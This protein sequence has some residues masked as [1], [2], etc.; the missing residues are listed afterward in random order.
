M[1]KLTI[2]C[3]DDERNVLL[4]LRT[5]L[6]RY[7]PEHSIEIA[8]SGVE[9]LELIAELL[10][11]GS[12]VPLVISDQIMPGMK[13]DQLLIELHQRY[14]QIV[15]V[16]LTGQARA[17]DVG[18]VVN[19]GNLYR[20][21]SKP[22]NEVDLQL[23]VSEALRRYQQ[24][25]QLAQQQLALEHSNQA[26]E[27]LNADLAQ[28]VQDR[29][30]SLQQALQNRQRTEA[31]L[32]VSEKQYRLLSEIS[33]MGIFRADL[34]GRCTY[35][36]ARALEIAGLSLA[37]NLA[38]GWGKTVHPEDRDDI[39]AAWSEFVEQVNLGHEAEYQIEHRY[40][41]PDHSIRWILVQ[42]VPERNAAGA[43]GCIGSMIDITEHK[44]LEERLQVTLE[45]L[46][47]FQ[48]ELHVQNEE[49][50]LLSRTAELEKI[51]YQDL[52][53]FAPDGYLVTD[54]QG[55]IQEANQAASDLLASS[56][57]FLVGKPLILFLPEPDRR[58]L[59][60]RLC[61]L[62]SLQTSQQWE[63]R[64]KPRNR[65]SFPA[66]ITVSASYSLEGE[67]IGYRCLFRD[68]TDRKRAETALRES[69]A[70]FRQFAE[71]VREGFF[72]IELTP[73]RYTYINS[74]YAAI[75]G[76]SAEEIYANSSHWIDNIYPDD[77]ERIEVAR[78]RELQGEPS[79]KEYRFVRASGEVCWLRSQAF[80]LRDQ[81]GTIYRLIGTIEDISERKHAEELLQNLNVELEQH[82]QK[83]TQDLQQA[84]SQLHDSES[85][86][87]IFMDNS[88]TAS[89][90]T[91]VNGII[92]Y[93]NRTYWRMFK[94]P[95][96]D[97]IG[98]SIFEFYPSEIAQKSLDNIQT[99][100]ATNQVLETIEIAP[101]PD[102]T[103][104]N[105]LVYKFPMTDS[106]G[107]CL[108]AGVA[109]DISE[110]KA[111]EAMLIAEQVR[112]QVALE[113]ADMGTWE[114]NL[115]TGTW[116]ERTEAIFGY[117]PGTFPGDREAFLNLVHP[118]DQEH[119][120]QALSHSFATQSLYNVEYRINRLDGELR[121]VFVRGKV[122]QDDQGPGLRM[123]GITLD[124]TER[125]RLEQ[126]L[127]QMNLELE[128]RVKARTT[129]L[130]TAM[131]AAQAANQAKTTFLSNMS[132]ELR[133]PL[134]AIMGFS[135]LLTRD[136]NL[137]SDQ[138]EKISI[139]NRNGEHLLNLIND[140]LAMSKIEAG[141]TKLT[142]DNFDLYALLNSLEDIFSLKSKSKGLQLTI[143]TDATVPRYIQTDAGKLRQ[144][145]MNLLGNSIKFTAQGEVILRVQRESHRGLNSPVSQPVALRF[146]VA[147]TGCGIDPAEQAIVF[148]PFGQTHVGQRL[149]EGTGLGL[150]I[151][152]QFVQLMGGELSLTSLPGQGSTFAFT[153][154]VALVQTENWQ[155]HSPTQR[156]IGLAA[157]QPNYRILIAEDNRDN[158]QFLAQL[159]GAV[160]FEVQMVANGQDA[161]ERWQR[162]HPDLIWMDMQ[163][164]VMDGYRATKCIRVLEQ[165][166]AIRNG[167]LGSKSQAQQS[168]K[169]L[170]LTASA[171]EDER[172]AILAAGCDDFVSKPTLEA[173]L[174][175]KIAEHLAVRYLY[176]AEAETTS[177]I[178]AR[179]TG[180]LST[181]LL[182][183]EALQVMPPDWIAQL[184]RAACIADEDL[185]LELLDQIPAH[186][187]WLAN[188]LK[189]LVDEFQLA[190]LIQL[191]L[192][193]GAAYP[194]TISETIVPSQIA[195]YQATSVGS[196]DSADR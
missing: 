92:L 107:Q 187:I 129:D 29:T 28:Q 71:T 170:A 160:G 30:H 105:F 64:L 135:Q 26:L 37:E 20:F 189:A 118:D 133:T 2:L 185:I 171:F 169:I 42:A 158:Q 60:H 76:F 106:S 142:M 70:R 132:H 45:E 190:Q 196:A 194:C 121:W 164:P 85:R 165:K 62:R 49:L 7:L 122:V 44:Q 9:A 195:H 66:S 74:A 116:S 84:Y 174:L 33:P 173:V 179:V 156:V 147:D 127:R 137:A 80:P 100:A 143:Q 67:L 148:E 65:S 144:V 86:F 183:P 25:Q 120:F 138:Q 23:T 47:C 63:L 181:D 140:I 145:L 99:V 3:V 57:D 93:L 13:G 68:I 12:D 69:E 52:F 186:Q 78:Q 4:T 139:I 110:R 159:L 193:E 125:K 152:R 151:S 184:H 55:L 77:R 108:I 172:A 40:L 88:P 131:E 115:E 98:K 97:A 168:T 8:E 72:V 24:E 27:T 113:A 114:S 89:W 36:N 15:K 126:E 87:Q 109:I 188:T 50:V 166:Q 104:G 10:A 128:R 150:S 82:V 51:R 58:T 146:E 162:W 18:N 182:S 75:T 192:A 53:N 41:Y 130:Q 81:T 177:P 119:V 48:E 39:D 96:T 22:W 134:N 17:E 95:A 1:R 101:R 32:R 90:I 112:L 5:Q 16:M 167:L 155:P 102:G 94:F 91:D 136:H 34:Q 175:E 191:T 123:I 141:Q 111:A 54:R 153:I 59:L 11:E 73:F 35:A 154:P 6:S 103:M 38:D 83:R 21:L 14:P 124:I 176:E 161:I 19:Q 43:V 61:Q 46:Q 79:D 117:A 157:D 149:Q 178:T 56:P 31:A 180:V 163:M